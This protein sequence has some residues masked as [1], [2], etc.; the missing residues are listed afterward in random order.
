MCLTT[1][2]FSEAWSELAVLLVKI[3]KIL[4]QSSERVGVMGVSYY[5]YMRNIPGQNWNIP[6]LNLYD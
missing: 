4:I 5:L 6:L 1:L 3:E 2:V